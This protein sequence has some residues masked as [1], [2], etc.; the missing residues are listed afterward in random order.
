MQSWVPLFVPIF[1]A[2]FR[3]AEDLATAMEARGFRGAQHRTRLHQLRMT[4]QDW[5][6]ALIAL[7]A[8]LAILGLE[9]SI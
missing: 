9:R 5:L 7:I 3:R 8:S 4:R 1:V 6:A 2:A